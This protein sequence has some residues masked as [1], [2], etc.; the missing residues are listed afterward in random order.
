MRTFKILQERVARFNADSEIQGL[1]REIRNRDEQLEGLMGG[2][3]SANASAIAALQIDRVG[4]GAEGRQ[5]E[6]LDQLTTELLL[7]VR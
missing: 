1:L 3:T 6:K 4:I 5:Y 7:G 2:Y